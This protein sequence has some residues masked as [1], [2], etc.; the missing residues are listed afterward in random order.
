MKRVAVIIFVAFTFS[1]AG[2]WS[3]RDKLSRSALNFYEAM[4]W[5]RQQ[6]MEDYLVG[7][8]GSGCSWNSKKAQV[9]DYEITKVEVFSSKRGAVYVD[10]QYN[11]VYETIVKRI[12]VKDLWEKKKSGWYCVKR[13]VISR[14]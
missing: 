1:C 12:N 3:P 7:D 8:G 5:N 9:V 11:T 10:I 2:A 13:V 6:Q 4:R 14:E